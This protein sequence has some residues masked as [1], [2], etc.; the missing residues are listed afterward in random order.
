MHH[1]LVFEVESKSFA[2]ELSKVEYV[3]NAIE[4][5]PTNQAKDLSMG[6]I[7]V[8]GELMTIFDARAIFGFTTKEIEVGDVFIILKEGSQS[9]ALN[10]DKVLEVLEFPKENLISIPAGAS[11][12]YCD[13]AIQYR[14]Q[15][16]P[17]LSFLNVLQTTKVEG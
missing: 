1:W 17:V 3:I 5:T 2:L 4:V 9:F 12:N 10:V 15:V 16:F 6:V 11:F 14:D 13:L 8:H 7:N